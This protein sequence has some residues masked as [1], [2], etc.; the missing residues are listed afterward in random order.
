[1]VVLE[2]VV[3]YELIELDQT[4]RIPCRA[5]RKPMDEDEQGAGVCRNEGYFDMLTMI[6][7]SPQSGLCIHYFIHVK[8]KCRR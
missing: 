3:N 1:V 5:A 8:L 2:L 7:S 6:C 4:W